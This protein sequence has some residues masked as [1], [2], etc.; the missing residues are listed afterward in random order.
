M[1]PEQMKPAPV[2]HLKKEMQQRT[3]GELLEICLRL[4]RFN[5]ENTKLLI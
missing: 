5:K 4:A 3:Q 2:T 1:L